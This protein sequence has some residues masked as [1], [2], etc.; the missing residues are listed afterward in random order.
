MTKHEFA[1]WFAEQVQPRWPSWQVNGVLLGDWYA[2]LGRCDV[3]TLTEAVRRHKIDDDRTAPSIRLVRAQVRRI[4]DAGLSRS[5]ATDR[6]VPPEDRVTAHEFWRQV[7]TT[8]DWEQRL[9]LMTQQI[10]FDPHARDKDPQAYD[11]LM[12]HR[13]AQTAGTPAP[14]P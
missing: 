3:A 9:A 13:A 7:R 14:P 8:F 11:R 10:K 12:E 6:T 4:A 2:A 5:T 1:A